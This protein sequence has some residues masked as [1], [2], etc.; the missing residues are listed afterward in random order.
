MNNAKIGQTQ[1]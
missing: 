1:S